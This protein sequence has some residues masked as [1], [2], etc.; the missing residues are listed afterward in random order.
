MQEQVIDQ[1]LLFQTLFQMNELK[2]MRGNPQ[3]VKAAIYD[4]LEK[5]KNQKVSTHGICTMHLGYIL[6]VFII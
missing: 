1:M 2:K 6:I 5:L 4:C 3:Y